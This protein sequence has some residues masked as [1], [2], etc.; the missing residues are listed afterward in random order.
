MESYAALQRA[1]RRKVVQRVWLTVLLCV[2]VGVPLAVWAL[3]RFEAS[4]VF[5]PERYVEG[6]AWEVPAGGEDVWFEAADGTRLHGWFVPAQGRRGADATVIFFHGNGGNL[7]GLGWLGEV[8]SRRGFDVL[9]FDYRGYGRSAGAARDERGIYMDADAAYDYAVKVR[10]A[11]PRR[12]VLYGQSLGTTA[13]TDV[14]AR[15]PCGAVILESGLS[16]AEEMGAL[17]LPGLPS[18]VYR[19]ARN[20][21][22]SARKLPGVRCPVL[23]AHGER[24]E[25]IPVAQGRNLY[26]AAPEP[27]EL[28]ILPAAGHNDMVAVGGEAYL[29]RLE[30][31]VRRS[32]GGAARPG[33]QGAAAE[34]PAAGA[35]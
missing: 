31:F 7:G 4:V 32:V 23:V 22:A 24:D 30:A 9:L 15:R 2:A 34:A 21:F 17:V 19:L 12:L 35:R 29:S 16:S 27:K 26:A 28:V 5:H 11:D 25:V 1:N 18:F 3:R 13:A 8:W 33:A 14:A 10:G 20:R 6:Q